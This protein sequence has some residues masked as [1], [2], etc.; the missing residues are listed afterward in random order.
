MQMI[1][2]AVLLV[3][4]VLNL[5]LAFI[6]W[7]MAAVTRRQVQKNM[8]RELENSA[9]A[10]DLKME[11]LKQLEEQKKKVQGEIDSLEGVVLSLKTSPFYAPRPIAR[12]LFIPTARYIDNEFFD[13]HKLV[14]DMMKDVDWKQIVQNIRSRYIYAGNRE[15]YETACRILEDLDMDTVYS[16][17]T[18]DPQEQE[19]ILEEAFTGRAKEMLEEFRSGLG[20]DEAFDVLKF[21]TYAREIRTKEDPRVY[22]RTGDRNPAKLDENPDIV[23]QYDSNISEGLKIIYQNRSFDFS[24]YRL[25]SRK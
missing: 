3:M 15:N 25:R 16:L 22:I 21:R 19:T 13:N 8:T 14:N 2:V 17:C 23:Y 9:A 12:E 6:I 5:F 20:E 7:Q 10:L 11:E 24:I 1:Y 18:R 4:A